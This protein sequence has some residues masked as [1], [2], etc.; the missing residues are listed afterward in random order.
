MLFCPIICLALLE[1]RYLNKDDDCRSTLISQYLYFVKKKSGFF[2]GKSD[3]H[4]W[5]LFTSRP[6]RRNEF[7]MEYTGEII[8]QEEANR[9][10]M[11]SD[12][13]N[14]SFLFELNVDL[15]VNKHFT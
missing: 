1:Y 12:Y 7:I 4:G 2:I 3:V 14:L 8:S 5:G 13:F 6:I 10:G 15:V 11:V 9:R